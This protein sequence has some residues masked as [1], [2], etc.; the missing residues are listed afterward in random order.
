MVAAAGVHSSAILRDGGAY[1]IINISFRK[2]LSALKTYQHQN[3]LIQNCSVEPIQFVK[4]IFI[5]RLVHLLGE[6]VVRI[7]SWMHF[8]CEREGG[9]SGCGTHT[10]AQKLKHHDLDSPLN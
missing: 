5:S 3:I 1:I 7:V 4:H 6:N 2:Y 10:F 9:R 8:L